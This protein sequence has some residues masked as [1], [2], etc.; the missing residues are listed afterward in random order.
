MNEFAVYAELGFRHI[1]AIHAL[2]HIFF[3]VVLAAVYRWRDWRQAVVVISAFT[4]GHSVTLVLSAQGWLRLPSPLVEFLIPLTVVATG[5]EN[6]AAPRHSTR[7]AHASIRPL[8]AGV[9][10]LVHGAGF[11]S[12]LQSMFVERIALPLFS[13]NIGI[14]AGQFVVLVMVF[15]L[16]A[17]FDRA[18]EWIRPRALGSI[19]TVRLRTVAVSAIIVVIAANWAVERAPW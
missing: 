2:D 18:L 15:S 16:L 7:R 13:F 1:V 12:Y 10:G 6:L 5:I 9:F 4:V 3:L 19:S 8:L 17:A 14:E 11:A